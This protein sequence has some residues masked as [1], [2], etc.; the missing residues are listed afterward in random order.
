MAGST[1]VENGQIKEVVDVELAQIFPAFRT[2]Q[3][4]PRT[5]HSTSVSLKTVWHTILYELG[6]LNL[7]KALESGYP[8]FVMS[9]F[10]KDLDNKLK[11]EFETKEAF[12]FAS[13]KSAEEC[14]EFVYKL[15]LGNKRLCK[16]YKINK[17]NIQDKIV[18]QKQDI[19]RENLFAIF[20]NESP[21][22]HKLSKAR[23]FVKK[24][25][26]RKNRKLNKLVVKSKNTRR[27]KSDKNLS[28]KIKE[29]FS[30]V[31]NN[32]KFIN[33]ESSLSLNAEI[34]K[35]VKL[36][37][38][39]TGSIVT[40]RHARAYLVGDPK[41]NTSSE[42]TRNQNTLS[43]QLKKR[44]KSFM[45]DTIKAIISIEK[46][47]LYPTGMAAMYDAFCATQ[48]FKEGKTIQIGIPYFDTLEIQ[49]KFGK[50]STVH[51]H[52]LDKDS[53]NKDYIDRIE[54]EIEDG[55]VSAVFMEFPSNPLLKCADLKRLSAVLRKNG[56]PLV[57]DQ[58]LGSWINVDLSEYADLIMDS[59]T[60]FTSGKSNVMGGSLV[61]N[62]KSPFAK[63]LGKIIKDNYTNSCHPD[64]LKVMLENSK[65]FERRMKKMSKNASELYKWF[66][67]TGDDKSFSDKYGKYISKV[68]FP[69]DSTQKDNFD[70]VKRDEDSGYGALMSLVFKDP[71][72]AV[73]FFDKLKVNKGPGLGTDFTLACMFTLLGY[74]DDLPAAAAQ[75]MPWHLVRFSFGT[76]NISLLK[77]RIEN[78][79]DYAIKICL[80]NRPV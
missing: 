72:M 78:A 46:I 51:L 18:L 40:S 36:Y 6:Q 64:D 22:D 10:A 5:D 47:G 70:H 29:L 31:S 11:E 28:K 52:D 71:R 30:Y 79:L 62:P 37:R 15:L 12:A 56:I 23:F 44:I 66:T 59:T 17:R 27:K 57:I 4:L 58:T 34:L 26:K 1:V 49:K 43:N 53:L 25:I 77:R 73:F 32:L 21:Q 67:G 35:A 45:P 69:E 48:R 76:E 68:Y 33:R 3:R 20:L 80:R 74:F 63:D 8:R 42:F 2:G 13:E 38:Q 9:I 24:K 54:R 75:N 16:E 65:D 19:Q 55:G 61:V 50:A 14:R 7:R 39:H 41:D 60:K